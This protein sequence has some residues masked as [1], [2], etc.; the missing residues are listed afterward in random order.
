MHIHR[1][2]ALGV[3]DDV[4]RLL[5]GFSSVEDS[6]SNQEDRLQDSM[7]L[8]DELNNRLTKVGSNIKQWMTWSP[9]ESKQAVLGFKAVLFMQVNNQLSP[10][11]TVLDDAAALIKPMKSQLDELNG[12]LQN[13]SQQAQD[14]QDSADNAVDE[15]ASANEV[16]NPL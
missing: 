13:G 15:A 1:D 8:I 4:D 3:K 6:L 14:A 10:A 11:E 16:R 12:L 7:D 5:S 2:T 9:F